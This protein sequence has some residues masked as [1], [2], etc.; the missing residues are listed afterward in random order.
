MSWVDYP[1]IDGTTPST[2]WSDFDLID[3]AVSSSFWTYFPLIAVDSNDRKQS[4]MSYYA[5]NS[6]VTSGNGFPFWPSIDIPAGA[7]FCNTTT[8]QFGH[9]AI[10]VKAGQKGWADPTGIIR[11][12]KP[13]SWFSVDGQIVH[14]SP[15]DQANGTFSATGGTIP[16]G[17]EVL[18]PS[19]ADSDWN[20]TDFIYVELKR[21]IKLPALP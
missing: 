7:I 17:Y 16:I 12:K 8:G 3:G 4:G 19:G 15:T 21:D 6:R 2:T 14:Y 20:T 5:P 9:N 11:F 10:L 1:L 13:A 18:P